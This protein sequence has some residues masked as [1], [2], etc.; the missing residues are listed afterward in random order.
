MADHAHDRRADR[1]GRADGPA[2]QVLTGF[3]RED[4]HELPNSLTWGP[5][6]WLYG[7]NGVF[8]N[9]H[10]RYGQDNTF[11]AASDKEK[12]PG[13]KINCA[14]FR[15]HPRTRE[16]QVFCEGTSNPWGV[17]WD[18]EGSAFISACVIEPMPPRAKPQA[19]MLPSTSPM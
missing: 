7:L 1:D 12:H 13:W 8:N 4:T 10:V 15:I 19:P 18:R 6:G 16:F 11:L 14:M 3:G 2:Q 17:A 5:D 9:C